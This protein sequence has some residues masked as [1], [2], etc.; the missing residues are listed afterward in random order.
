[1]IQVQPRFSEKEEWLDYAKKRTLRFE[2]LEFSSVYLNELGGDEKQFEWYR[3]SGLVDSIHGF[4]MD[5][6]PL[7]PDNEIREVS[8]ARCLKSCHQAKMTGAKNVVFHSTALP[9]VRG[10]LET[11][12]GRDAAEYYEHLAEEQDLNIF[13]ENF[14]DVDPVPLVRMMENVKGERLKVCLDVG[15]A[16]YSKCGINEWISALGDHIGYLHISDNKGLWDDHMILGEGSVDLFAA[17]E[18]YRKKNGNIPVTI[19]VH[20]LR[21]LDA[22]IAF[23]QREGLFG[24]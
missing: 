18:Y 24:F 19:E 10:G 12:W 11:L 2:I 3:N 23:L 13:I 6:Y 16:N 17:D 14:N 7:S 15:H 21:E 8:R 1:M 20:T 5:C 22:S 9:F 4:F